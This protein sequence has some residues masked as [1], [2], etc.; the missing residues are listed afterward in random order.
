MLEII[1]NE[2]ILHYKYIG[3]SQKVIP[4]KIV[5]VILWINC[6]LFVACGFIYCKSRQW[7]S[8]FDH[9]GR[10]QLKISVRDGNWNV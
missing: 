5:M 2:G 3:H 10:D 6:L 7:L 8:I 9:I 4:I 1:G